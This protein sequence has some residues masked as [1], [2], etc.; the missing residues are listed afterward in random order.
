MRT[1]VVLTIVIVLG[2]CTNRGNDDETTTPAPSQPQRVEVLS[3]FQLVGEIDE[4][5]AGAEPKVDVPDADEAPVEE[6]DEQQ[7]AG[8]PTL[9]PDD[10]TP[11]V[12][13]AASGGIM[14]ITVEDAS[15]ELST[16]C[17]VIA[18]DAVDVYWTTD[19]SF[20]PADVLDA[21]DGVEDEIEGRV[22]GVAGR[23]LGT[24]D[25]NETPRPTLALGTAEDEDSN[26]TGSPDIFGPGNDLR[27]DADENDDDC[28]LVADQVGF[29]SDALPTP[30]QPGSRPVAP[31][32]ATPDATSA[33][34]Q[35]AEPQPT[36]STTRRPPSTPRETA[37]STAE[38]D[39]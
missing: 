13:T 11:P 14:R 1:F 5:F 2:G 9:A 32:P 19:T 26:V 29:E 17:G 10:Q 37:T 8:A 28:L 3:D 34:E 30:S 4:A 31:R 38:A 21:I 24:A 6:E 20:D 16:R 22:A 18:D 33:P 39:M 12:S 27:S 36:P 7:D 23:I 35:T 25:G 15:S